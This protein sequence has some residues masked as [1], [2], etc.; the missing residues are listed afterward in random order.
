MDV[1]AGRAGRSIK[2]F[3]SMVF[4]SMAKQLR[5]EK[6]YSLLKCGLYAVSI[7][8]SGFLF[9]GCDSGPGGSSPSAMKMEAK[10]KGSV[11]DQKGPI[12]EG[13]IEVKD[14]SGA[15]VTTTPFTGSQYSVTIP[16]TAAYPIVITAYPAAGAMSADPVKAVVTSPLA[17]RMDV[18]AVTTN[19]VDNA[20]ALGGL[21]AENIA[22]A[23]G[24]AIG[25]RQAQ[26]VS[27]GAGGGGAGP[28]QSGGGAG[29]G[30]HAGH[31]MSDKSSGSTSGKT[32][33][34]Q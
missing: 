18:S 32:D 1:S 12:S 20:I 25:M 19:V 29:K 3:T 31:D 34:E 28:G 7:I 27:A 14:T 6:R 9:S 8:F 5:T 16:A 33:S 26:G 30:G 13:K 10:I 15:V 21:T 17:D 24:G 23:S 22:K 2:S 11:S 4:I